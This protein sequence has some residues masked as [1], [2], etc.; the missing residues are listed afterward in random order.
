MKKKLEQFRLP[1]DLVDEL[2]A[3]SEASG[4]SK[5]D[6]VEHALRDQME[7]SIS[8]RL[9]ARIKAVKK[10]G[11]SRLSRAIHHSQESGKRQTTESP[12]ENKASREAAG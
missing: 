8:Q 3:Y 7:K 10:L 2:E 11:V 9:D 1:Q 4:I 12:S 5:T 6:I